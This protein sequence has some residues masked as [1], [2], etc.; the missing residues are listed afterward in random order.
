MKGL[1]IQLKDEILE[2]FRRVA[3]RVFGYSKRSLS[4]ATESAIINWLEAIEI[5]YEE[6]LEEDPVEVI[7]GLLEELD[8][9]SVELQ[10]NLSKFWLQGT[11]DD[12]SN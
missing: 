7:D 1:L 2:K 10:H 3:T 6:E 9:D 4:Q 11:K 8:I 12:I 5:P